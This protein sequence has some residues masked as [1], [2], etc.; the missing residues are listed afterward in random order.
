MRIK[1]SQVLLST[2]ELQR[3]HDHLPIDLLEVVNRRGVLNLAMGGGLAVLS[4]LCA[5]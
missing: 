2:F 4:C 1:S 3:P 5:F